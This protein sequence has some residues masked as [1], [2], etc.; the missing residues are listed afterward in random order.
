MQPT[1]TENSIA[2]KLIAAHDG[3]VA[4][5]YIYR[6]RTGCLDPEQAAGDLCRTLKDILAAEEKLRRM[7]LAE[8][9]AP[10]RRAPVDV[11]EELPEYRS[12]DIKQRSQEDPRFKDIL[13]E[14]RVVVGRPISSPEMEIFFRIYTYY[15]LSPEVIFMLLHHC[16]TTVKRRWGS[17]R[18]PTPHYIEKE[19]ANWANH[20]L[21]TI[22]AA[23]EYLRRQEERADVLNRLKAAFSIRDRELSKSERDY[24]SAWLDMGFGEEAILLAYDRTV[25][26][27]GA[28]K[29]P[30]MNKILCSWHQK[31]LHEPKEI[32]E[33][34]VRGGRARNGAGSRSRQ[35]QP[36]DIGQ[37]QHSLEKL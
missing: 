26:Q 32:E 7:G 18:R 14:A 37:L 13:D 10:A 36:V 21:L 24:L 35:D 15:A 31:G 25:T 27:T 30:Y 29:W 2:D 23:E 22:E 8:A 16:E 11:V 1:K 12:S 19:A 17:S 3:D 4:L 28:L 5:L 20:E 6:R 9:P 34:D 33:K